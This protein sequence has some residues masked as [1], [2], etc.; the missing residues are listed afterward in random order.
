MKKIVALLIVATMLFGM[1]GTGFAATTTAFSDVAGTKYEADVAK[2]KA[3]EV[4]GGYLD[5]T[6]RPTENVTRSQFAVMVVNALNMNSAAKALAGIKPAFGDVADGYYANGFVNV[7]VGQNVISGYPDGTFKG[8]NPVTYTEALIMLTR[9]LGY[10]ITD[11]T[12][13]VV[14]AFELELTDG[15]EYSVASAPRGD[16]AIM[17]S[18][19]IE[20]P[21]AK[22]DADG[23]LDE[24]QPAMI[25]KLAASDSGTTP[26]VVTNTQVTDSTLYDE[27]EDEVSIELDSVSKVIAYGNYDNLL[28]EEV[29]AFYNKDGEVIYLSVETKADNKITGKLD[30]SYATNGNKLKFEGSSKKYELAAGYTFFYNNVTSVDTTKF[31]DGKTVTVFLGTDGKVRFAIL[32]DYVV[33]DG[34]VTKLTPRDDARDKNAKIEYTYETAAP[35]AGTAIIEVAKDAKITRNGAVATFADL[36]EDDVIFVKQ[37]GG[38]LASEVIATAE[39]VEGKVTSVR[40]EVEKVTIAGTTYELSS[41]ALIDNGTSVVA[42]DEDLVVPN[43]VLNKNVVLYLNKDGKVAFMELKDT[44]SVTGLFVKATKAKYGITDYADTITLNVAGEEKTYK[45]E[46]DTVSSFVWNKDWDA[47]PGTEDYDDYVD[48]LNQLV[49][50]TLDVDGAFTAVQ[51]VAVDNVDGNDLDVVADVYVIADKGINTTSKTIKFNSKTSSEVYVYFYDAS[52]KVYDIV[53]DV[54]LTVSDLSKDTEVQVVE[55][56]TDATVLDFIIVTNAATDSDNDVYGIV[57]DKYTTY[58]NST[59]KYFVEMYVN[60]ELK[61]YEVNSGVFG[62]LTADAVAKLTFT[63]SKVSAVNSGISIVSKTVDANS[64]DAVDSTFT[65]DVAATT[66]KVTAATVIYDMTGDDPAVGS[67]D[68][69]KDAAG[70]MSAVDLIAGDTVGSVV[71][72][73]YLVIK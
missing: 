18:N 36:Q 37:D 56:S 12:S 73:K 3:L 39:K 38:T 8:E 68:D 67:F 69:L 30:E 35:A 57:D 5:G 46:E 70:E 6:F 19:T 66:Y 45:I 28:G 33:K 55:D 17:L 10:K 4:V 43:D 59:T 2:L 44:S 54:Y 15:V 52:T 65:V 29:K 58:T 14:K 11:P 34:F 64:I 51:Y 22:Y 13:A 72:V 9:A 26:L 27:D 53:N 41:Y 42:E 63:G 61:T 25:S 62:S 1:V 31:D 7:A 60:G 50:L 47:A 24:T 49:K 71:L 32:N 20:K 48:A 40:G 21:K 16:L 23:N